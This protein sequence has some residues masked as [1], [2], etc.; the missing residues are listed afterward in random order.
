MLVCLT[1]EWK[2][3][4]LLRQDYELKTQQLC[5]NV[6]GGEVSCTTLRKGNT[7]SS[8]SSLIGNTLQMNDVTAKQQNECNTRETGNPLL[9]L[10]KIQQNIINKPL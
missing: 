5:Q 8:N 7:S 6:S 10:F 3:N 4:N 2:T 1:T 9:S